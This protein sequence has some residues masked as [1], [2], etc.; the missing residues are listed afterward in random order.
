M[1]VL[2]F[3]SHVSIIML[4]EFLSLVAIDKILLYVKIYSII[5]YTPI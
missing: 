1:T 4:F 2:A 3:T 5:S